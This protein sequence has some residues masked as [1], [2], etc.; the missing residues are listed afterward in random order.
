MITLKPLYDQVIIQQ[1]NNTS[2]IVLET[3]N[4][5]PRLGTVVATGQGRITLSGTLAP[6]AV[7]VGD[8]VYY[9]PAQATELKHEGIAYDIISDAEILC[10]KSSVTENEDE[11]LLPTEWEIEMLQDEETKQTELDMT[12]TAKDVN[13]EES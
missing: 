10:I 6:L 13:S 9:H 3:S 8:E 1:Q 12:L 2:L 4:D 11:V 5:Q 7:K